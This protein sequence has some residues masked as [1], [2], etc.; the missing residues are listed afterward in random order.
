[1]VTTY[2][3]QMQAILFVGRALVPTL[4]LTTNASSSTMHREAIAMGLFFMTHNR[5]PCVRTRLGARAFIPTFVLII[6]TS[7]LVVL[8]VLAPP[9]RTHNPVLHVTALVNNILQ[10]SMSLVLISVQKEN[11]QVGP[12]VL[13]LQDNSPMIHKLVNCVVTVVILL[14]INA[15]RVN[16]R[17]AVNAKGYIQVPGTRKPAH[18]VIWG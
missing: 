2:T 16:I 7:Q 9:Q 5:V 12:T 1:M 15:Q 13:R 6:H 17:Q 14:H 3:A 8:H 4:P 18:L 10:F 11:I